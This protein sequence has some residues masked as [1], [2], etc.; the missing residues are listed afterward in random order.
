MGTTNRMVDR[1]SNSG[2]T[3]AI[4]H[5]SYSTPAK[6]PAASWCNGRQRGW[7]L[8]LNS[9]IRAMESQENLVAFLCEMRAE[10]GVKREIICMDRFKALKGLHACRR[11]IPNLV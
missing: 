7:G 4:V 11:A 5:S 2:G 10:K 8:D 6:A 1:E 3:A 9:P